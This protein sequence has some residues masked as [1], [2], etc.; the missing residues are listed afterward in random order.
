MQAASPSSRPWTAPLGVLGSL[1]AGA[2]RRAAALASDEAKLRAAAAAAPPPPSMAAALFTPLV[3]VI[4]EVKRR[5]PSKGAIRPGIST[6]RQVAAYER[7]GAAVLSILTE[8]EQFGG[9]PEDLVAA[10]RGSA[11][12]LLRKDFLVHELQLVEA[13]ALGASAV[14]LIARALSPHR[15]REMAVAAAE[16]GLE[17]LVEVRDE[18]EMADALSVRATI[19]GVNNRDLETLAV[20]PAASER[21]LPLVPRDRI[22]IAESGVQTRDDVERF[23]ACGADA[24]LVGSSVSASDD[25]AAAVRALVGVARHGR[26]A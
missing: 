4:A 7:G 26:L 16:L 18:R 24:V 19:I 23:A 22:A 25:P 3:G 10:R 8:P 15:L 11:L 14:L 20:D 9:S 6:D 17:T 21:L 1:V 5:S 12:P 2:E 13:R